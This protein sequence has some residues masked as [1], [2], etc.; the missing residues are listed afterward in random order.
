MTNA[1]GVRDLY[2]TDVDGDGHV[3][4]LLA[5]A[6]TDEK[7]AWYKNDGN[8]NPS[9]TEYVIQHTENV[10]QARGH[11]KWTMHTY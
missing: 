8:A 6:F 3:D 4:I 10:G 5:F 11:K 2:A 1:N 9:F 7:I